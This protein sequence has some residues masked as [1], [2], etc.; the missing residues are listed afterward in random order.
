MPR[1]PAPLPPSEYPVLLRRSTT[2][3]PEHLGVPRDVLH[4]ARK[5]AGQATFA[6]GRRDAI[7]RHLLLVA[8]CRTGW[9]SFVAR[10]PLFHTPG[11][12]VADPRREA[13]YWSLDPG[14]P[15]GFESTAAE[16]LAELLR[17]A[18]GLSTPEPG[19]VT[20]EPRI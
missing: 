13:F 9:M 10:I 15:T 19:V 8:A 20:V 5:L 6:K 11:L 16:R 7:A 14:L 12:L 1:L 18:L 2:W 4:E 17:D 3:L